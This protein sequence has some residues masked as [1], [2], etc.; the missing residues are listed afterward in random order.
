MRN[1]GTLPEGSLKTFGDAIRFYR[2][3]KQ[4]ASSYP[5][6]KY[7][8]D[9]PDTE[10]GKVAIEE[11]RDRFGKFLDILK[12]DTKNRFSRPISKTTINR[13]IV[14]AKAVCNLCVKYE[15]IEG[16]PLAPYSKVCKEVGRDRVLSDKERQ[17]LSECPCAENQ[18]PS[19]GGSLCLA[20]PNPER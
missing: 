9:K 8:L 5:Q 17:N 12:I 18:A 13:F 16:N 19:S 15:L 4:E 11:L 20:S 1:P 10:I 3:K 14:Y 7:I 2:N 6:N